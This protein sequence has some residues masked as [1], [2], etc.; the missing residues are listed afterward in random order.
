[1]VVDWKTSDS[2]DKENKWEKMLGPLYDYDACN[3]NEYTVQVQMYKKAL[4][5]TYGISTPD[6]VDTYI[7]QFSKE[8]NPNGNYLILLYCLVLFILFLIF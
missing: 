3:L 8:V 5:E 2:I 4:C 6:K 1:M 7:C